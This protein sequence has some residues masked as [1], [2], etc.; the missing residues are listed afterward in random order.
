MQ[1]TKI[2]LVYL[3]Q[4]DGGTECV[5]EDAMFIIQKTPLG[6]FGA[7]GNGKY[8]YFLMTLI[9]K[10]ILQKTEH[11]CNI[12]KNSIQYTITHIMLGII[13]YQIRPHKI[14]NLFIVH[15]FS[16]L[17]EGFHFHFLLFIFYFHIFTVL[18]F[19]KYGIVIL[20]I[21][22]F[23][24]VHFLSN[25]KVFYHKKDKHLYFKENWEQ[26]IKLNIIINSQIYL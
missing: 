19:Q 21:F 5:I 10:E 3:H 26:T 4:F 9:G 25:V 22:H 12:I 24:T 7:H 16:N 1:G 11:I 13:F 2:Q 18:E 8:T 23:Q 20:F 17:E 15:N 14:N 6:T